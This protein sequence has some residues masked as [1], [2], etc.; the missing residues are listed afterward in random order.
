MI[1]GSLQEHASRQMIDNQGGVA[2]CPTIGTTDLSLPKLIEMNEEITT[3]VI[4]MIEKEGWQDHA[5]RIHGTNGLAPAQNAHTGGNL[6]TKIVEPKTE[7]DGQFRIRKL[8]PRECFRLMGCDE[9]TIDKLLN[10]G[11]SQSQLYKLA[12]NSI[13]VDVLYHIF[14]KMFVEKGNEDKQLSIF[15]YI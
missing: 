6:E 3:E 15:D 9:Q 1:L 10:A 13:V 4:G 7:I 11:I 12:G 5:R 14:R 2:T 8:T